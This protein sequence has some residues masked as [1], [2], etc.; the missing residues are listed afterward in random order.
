GDITGDPK[1]KMQWAQYFR[2][3]V[4]R[5]RV[6]ID[7]WPEAIP[8]ANLSSM[9]SSLPQLEILL[10]KWEMG[11]TYWK[12]LSDD[13]FEQLQQK[14]SEELESGGIE[15]CSRRTRSDKGKKR[16]H[17]SSATASNKKYKSAATID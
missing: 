4:A 17:H 6:I 5:Y 1:A 10:R 16:T 11:T 9:S 3:V 13:E 15:E 14:R 12:A 7:G 8:F 2:N